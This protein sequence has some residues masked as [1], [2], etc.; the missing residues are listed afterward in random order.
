MIVAPAA[1]L[2]TK[3]YEH[4]IKIRLSY[5][6]VNILDAVNMA[7]KY[8]RD[9]PEGF[10]NRIERVAIVGVCCPGYLKLCE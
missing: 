6:T 7:P 5:Y 2:R 3:V 4:L 9:Q 10:V 8:A 1:Q